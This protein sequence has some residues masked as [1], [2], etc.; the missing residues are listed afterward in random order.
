MVCAVSSEKIHT[1]RNAAT[2]LQRAV[3]STRLSR[4][5]TMTE[6]FLLCK[7]FAPDRPPFRLERAPPRSQS[8]I[9]CYITL[10]MWPPRVSLGS[11]R[12]TTV[13]FKFLSV[14]IWIL[15]GTRWKL[16]RSQT[17]PLHQYPPAMSLPSDALSAYVG[18][19]SDAAGLTV[20]ISRDGNSL[21]SS[22]NGEKPTP[23]VSSEKRS[24]APPTELRLA[25][26]SSGKR[27]PAIHQLQMTRK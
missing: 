15:C 26:S 27:E 19:Y 8:P 5:S 4:S 17:F 23:K 14:E 3:I 25:V 10:V 21:A 24:I 16:M 12:L 11:R 9:G 2:S 18:E 7:P 20:T 1:A 22:V 6:S 13:D